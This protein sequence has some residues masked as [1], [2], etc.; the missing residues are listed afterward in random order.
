MAD[1]TK[2]KLMPPKFQDDFVNKTR[3][4]ISD[5]YYTSISLP[6]NMSID[7]FD[8]LWQ[9]F[10]DT[11]SACNE[12]YNNIKFNI[13]LPAHEQAFYFHFDIDKIF[14]K[15]IELD[16]IDRIFSPIFL[17]FV[18]DTNE[19]IVKITR[20]K[21]SVNTPFIRVFCNFS[22]SNRSQYS[23]YIKSFDMCQTVHVFYH[24]PIDDE[25][26]IKQNNTCRELMLV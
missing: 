21:D 24:L 23:R 16:T 20:A 5:E 19:Y 18:L 9:Y 15:F 8:R 7:V 12:K 11:D 1:H 10:C 6:K 26:L 3:P 4:I 2:L 25:F 22:D 14:G 13:E 17:C